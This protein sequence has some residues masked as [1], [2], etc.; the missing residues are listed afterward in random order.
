MFSKPT[1]N[2]HLFASIKGIVVRGISYVGGSVKNLMLHYIS[3]K[4]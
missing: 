3:S 2:K 4:N 1:E